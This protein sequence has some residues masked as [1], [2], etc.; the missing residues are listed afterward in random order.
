[1]DEPEVDATDSSTARRGV[2]A[3][4]RERA[5]GEDARAEGRAPPTRSARRDGPRARRDS[6]VTA[7]GT[8]ARASDDGT[9]MATWRA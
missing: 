4:D 8:P 1:V 6:M 5:A 3:R 7:G 9:T 2:A